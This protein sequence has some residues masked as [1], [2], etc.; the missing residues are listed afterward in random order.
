[1]SLAVL[2][3]HNLRWDGVGPKAKR[4][5]EA[6][7]AEKLKAIRDLV[8]AT[9][10]FTEARGD[11]LTVETLPFDSTLT[12]EPPSL[13]PALVTMPAN[14]LPPW[15]Q[16]YVKDMSPG[17]LIGI[18]VG[19]LLVLIAP[20]L[21]LLMRK[22]KSPAGDVTSDRALP[23]ANPEATFEGQMAS[24]AANQERLDAEALLALKVPPPG[25]K[26]SEILVKHLKK[27]VKA[28]PA[29]SAQ[30][31]RTWMDETDN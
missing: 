23:G 17:L 9:T 11:L 2:V 14:G 28:D 22:R 24:R 20:I 18:G 26:K 31:L 6:P 1:M 3:D 25:T 19:A 5:L 27:S 15:L 10:G 30:L 4:I 12:A 8:A 29:S 13:P 7:T 21:F 16:K